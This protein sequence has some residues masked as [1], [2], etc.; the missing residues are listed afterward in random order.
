MNSLI[1]HNKD[2]AQQYR[3]FMIAIQ[4][5]ELKKL[6]HL[7]FMVT[8]SNA[9]IELP[10]TIKAEENTKYVEEA[11]KLRDRILIKIASCDAALQNIKNLAKE[12][13][14]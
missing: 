3:K 11:A 12:I 2:M 6:N 8:L 5:I 14:C 10:Y 7:N 13:L 9:M 1:H 4:K